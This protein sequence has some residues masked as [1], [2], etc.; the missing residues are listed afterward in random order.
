MN[1]G[2]RSPQFIHASKC[3]CVRIFMCVCIMCV[4]MYVC[5]TFVRIF[6][7]LYH[8]F[9]QRIRQPSS[10]N[11]YMHAYIHKVHEGRSPLHTKKH[12]LLYTFIYTHLYIHIHAYMHTADK[13]VMHTCMRTHICINTC[14]RTH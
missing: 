8:V 9:L 3:E 10:I 12:T 11:T 2:A 13:V 7:L 4:F 6:S 5:I 1:C 14:T